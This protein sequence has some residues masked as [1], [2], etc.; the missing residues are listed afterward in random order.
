MT[1][2][3]EDIIKKFYSKPQ[4]GAGPFP[5]YR[6]SR[7][8]QM[9]GSF[10]S[11][12]ARFAMPILKFLAPKVIR[13]AGNVASDVIDKKPFGASLAHHTGQEIKDTIVG[14]KR[15]APTNINKH[16]KRP[17]DNLLKKQRK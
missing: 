15:K 17:K 2:K 13:V 16:A 1:N 10:L 6:G 11:G 14:R 9:G 7:R 12:L 5:V 8:Q 3:Q 4:L